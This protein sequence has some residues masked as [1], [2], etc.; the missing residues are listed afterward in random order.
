M[1]NETLLFLRVRVWRM[2][3]AATG[4]RLSKKKGTYMALELCCGGRLC[5]NHVGEGCVKTMQNLL[6]L[7]ICC[8][9]CRNALFLFQDTPYREHENSNICNSNKADGATSG[10]I[11][12]FLTQLNFQKFQTGFTNRLSQWFFQKFLM[13]P[14]GKMCSEFFEI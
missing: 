5:G 14:V 8:S 4:N 1:T 9:M 6:F 11:I 7:Q 12:Y 3:T 2:H 10:K 13:K